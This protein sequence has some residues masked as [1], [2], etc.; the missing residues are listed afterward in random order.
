MRKSLNYLIPAML[1]LSSC[2]PPVWTKPGASQQ[3][4]ATDSYQCEKDARQSGY[5]GGGIVGAANMVDFQQRCMVAHGWRKLDQNA[6]ARS[7]PV[8]ARL[9][10][11]AAVRKACLRTVRE[12]PEFAPLQS[13]MSDIATG[14]FAPS[15]IADAR[16][17]TKSEIL[18]YSR[19]FD[20]VAPCSTEFTSSVQSLSPEIATLS[21]Q[22]HV[23]ERA[24]FSRL[25]AG[26][27][28]WGE[29]SSQWQSD[30]EAAS[31]KMQSIR[32]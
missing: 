1:I 27:I 3:D 6:V 31:V 26:Q 20:Q 29:A 15:Q 24:T 9:S 18:L 7:A 19:Y 2:A 13:H 11:L 21:A 32:L 25:A 22:Q 16:H 8:M 5:F 23:I 12:R 28:T 17:A 10:E 14:R 30:R 4:Y